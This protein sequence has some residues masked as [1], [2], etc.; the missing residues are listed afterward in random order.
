MST[1]HSQFWKLQATRNPDAELRAP[2]FAQHQQ[3]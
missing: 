2:E 1:E 3:H